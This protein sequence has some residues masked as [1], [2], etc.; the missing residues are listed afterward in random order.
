MLVEDYCSSAYPKYC[1]NIRHKRLYDAPGNVGQWLQT[2]TPPEITIR[3]Q[4]DIDTNTVVQVLKSRV[5]TLSIK[6]Y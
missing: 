3:H 1:P 5:F 6:E 2:V 4:G